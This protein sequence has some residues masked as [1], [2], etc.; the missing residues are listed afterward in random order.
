MIG[1]QPHGREQDVADDPITFHRDQRDGG[2][3]RSTYRLDKTP[4]VRS[5][6]RVL[7][8]AGDFRL[9]VGPLPPNKNIAHLQTLAH[10]ARH[11]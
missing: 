3:T 7:V 1:A 5:A 9:I 8:D 10:G 4:L 11:A 2:V 6:E